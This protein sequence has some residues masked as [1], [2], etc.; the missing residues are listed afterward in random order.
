[1][2]SPWQPIETVHGSALRHQQWFQFCFLSFL[3]Y[4][5]VS[6]SNAD[7]SPRMTSKG[8]FL[9]RMPPTTRSWPQASTSSFKDRFVVGTARGLAGHLWRCGTLVENQETLATPSLVR[10]LSYGTEARSMQIDRAG[11]RSK[12]PIHADTMAG[13][14]YIT[15]T[16]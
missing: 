13:P 8:P 7:H 9:S 14:L 12:Q 5:W 11:I 15:I 3:P 1:M 6:R 10:T 2:G 4:P 16:R